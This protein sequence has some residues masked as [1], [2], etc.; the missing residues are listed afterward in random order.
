[1]VYIAIILYSSFHSYDRTFKATVDRF[2]LQIR[3]TEQEADSLL[4][5]TLYQKRGK[6]CDSISLLIRNRYMEDVVSFLF[7]EGNDTLYIRKKKNFGNYFR[8]KNKI[9]I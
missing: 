5:F 8:Q 1:M 2:G 9:N 3:F 6:T 7:V 4:N